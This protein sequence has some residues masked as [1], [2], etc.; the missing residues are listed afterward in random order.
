MKTSVK[1]ELKGHILDKI[2]DGILTNENK[3]MY[4]YDRTKTE[5][6]LQGENEPEE[7]I[8]YFKNS[9]SKWVDGKDPD[10]DVTFVVIKV[11]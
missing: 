4:G 5:L 3:E 1:N 6:Q 10:D 8:E 2:N 11:K 7:I 9:A